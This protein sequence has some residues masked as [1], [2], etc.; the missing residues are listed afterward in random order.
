MVKTET[1]CRNPIRRTFGRIPWRVIPEPPGTLQGAATW[2]IQCHDSRATCHISGTWRNQRHDRAT[3]QG[4]IIPSAILKI[5]FRHILFFWIFKYAFWAL[6]SV[7][8]RIVSDTLVYISLSVPMYQVFGTYGVCNDPFSKSLV[9]PETDIFR[10]CAVSLLYVTPP[11]Y[12]SRLF[13]EVCEHADPKGRATLSMIC[14]CRRTTVELFARSW[15]SR[16]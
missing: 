16:L 12:S 8:F 1:R 7:G 10:V 4:V 11:I 15:I 6:T 14:R 13:V 5:V 3:L 2:R 9:H